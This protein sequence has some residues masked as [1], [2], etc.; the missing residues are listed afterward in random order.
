MSGDLLPAGWLTTEEAQTLTGY[1]IAHLRRLARDGRVTARKL[2]GQLW[3]FERESLTAYQ[4]TV[5]PGPKLK[6]KQA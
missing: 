6:T 1:S 3:L 4:A 2:A 5:R